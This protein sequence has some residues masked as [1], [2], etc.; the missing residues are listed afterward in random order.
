MNDRPGDAGHE[1]SAWLAT[2]AGRYLLEWEREQFDAAVADAFGYNA[3]QLGL[4]ELPALSANRMPHRWVALPECWAAE[5]SEAG[6]AAEAGEAY[7]PLSAT[8]P[9]SQAASQPAVALVTHAAALPFPAASLDLLVLPHTLELSADPHAVLREVERVLV[10][11]GRVVISVLNPASLWGLTQQRAQWCE[12]MGVQRY[13]LSERFVPETGDLI[14]P[15]RLRDW[16][17]LLSFEVETSRYGCFRPAVHSEKWLQRWAWMDRH[18][19]R[20]WPFL[21]AV[22]LVSAVKKVRGMHLL[23]PAWKPARA[24]TAPVGVTQRPS[25]R[26]PAP[27]AAQ[28]PSSRTATHTSS[29]SPRKTH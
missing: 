2:P 6:E 21:G 25:L 12:R 3:L 11:E 15:W 20:M 9:P 16:L 1:L 13:G 27:C 23:G 10:P 19:K 4:P 14:A 28:A 17:R 24:A 18:G 29:T 7:V 22:Y 8:V 5:A 26:Q